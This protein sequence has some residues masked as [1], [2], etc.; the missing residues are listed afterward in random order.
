M[1]RPA[2]RDLVAAARKLRPQIR[3]AQAELD[4]ARR[5][6]PSPVEALSETG[7]LRGA[8]LIDLPLSSIPILRRHHRTDWRTAS[9]FVVRM[10]RFAMGRP[11]DLKTEP[12]RGIPVSK[13]GALSW[14]AG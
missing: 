14:I 3:A 8:G 9:P 11:G 1:S 10:L 12:M 13:Q 6:P 2:H 5:L 4:D 7:R